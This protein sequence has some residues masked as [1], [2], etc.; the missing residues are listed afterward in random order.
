M[1]FFLIF[2]FYWD[3]N[4]NFKNYYADSRD[5]SSDFLGSG[6][7]GRVYKAKHINPLSATDI[8]PPAIAKK[9]IQLSSDSERE[10]YQKTTKKT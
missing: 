5:G 9:I 10:K 2:P 6:Q 4:F 1:K 7:Y 3:Y 8:E